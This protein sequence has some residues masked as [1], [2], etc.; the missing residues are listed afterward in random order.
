[1][2]PEHLR[3]A[4]D[5][6]VAVDVRSERLRERPA[7]TFILG[8][9]GVGAAS[10]QPPRGRIRARQQVIEDADI[11]EDHDATH[12]V[13]VAKR[14]ERPFAPTRHFRQSPARPADPRHNLIRAAPPDRR[15]SGPDHLGDL[16]NPPGSDHDNH[17]LPA[18]DDKRRAAISPGT[19]LKS[20]PQEVKARPVCQLR[21]QGD[22]GNDVVGVRHEPGGRRSP[23]G[24]VMSEQPTRQR[25]FEELALG[26]LTG[27]SQELLPFGVAA[28]EL[29]AH[30]LCVVD[31]ASGQRDRR[32]VP[33]GAGTR[34]RHHRIPQHLLAGAQSPHQGLQR[35]KVLRPPLAELTHEPQLGP[36]RRSPGLRATDEREDVLRA[37]PVEPGREGI[38][39]H[40]DPGDRWYTLASRVGHSPAH[41][42][43]PPLERCQYTSRRRRNLVDRRPG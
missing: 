12:A 1:M 32:R 6:Q 28:L 35:E 15:R 23:R 30:G 29:A 4:D 40:T 3:G 42:H 13:R 20:R 22:R 33:L 36:G 41:L 10:A 43:R 31:Q 37:Q 24:V 25:R 19:A 16:G 14:E 26:Q 27:S 34:L 5:V 11:I 8:K 7:L 9:Q 17:V 18:D 2:K 21:A 38:V 39:V